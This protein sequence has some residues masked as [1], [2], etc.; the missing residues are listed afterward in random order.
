MSAGKVLTVLAVAALVT[1]AIT[2][3][4]NKDAALALSIGGIGLNLF[5]LRFKKRSKELI[6]QAIWFKNKEILFGLQP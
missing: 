3:K 4:D 6:D 2:K 1:G 5:S